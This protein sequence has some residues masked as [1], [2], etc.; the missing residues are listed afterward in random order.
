M[1]LEKENTKYIDTPEFVIL[2]L[3]DYQVDMLEKD[4]EQL[5]QLKSDIFYMIKNYNNKYD[6]C[7]VYL[8]LKGRIKK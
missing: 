2:E 5:K 1:K 3:I 7:D 8:R 6:W 4:I